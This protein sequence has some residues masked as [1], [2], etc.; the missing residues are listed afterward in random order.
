MRANAA[1]TRV[2]CAGIVDA[3]AYD[4]TE[5]QLLQSK[6]IAILPVSEVENLFFLPSVIEAIATAEGYEGATLEAK[7]APIFEELFTQA[8][9]PKIQLPIVMRYCRRRIDRTLKKID[10]SAAADVAALASDYT[11]KTSALD[12]AALAKAAA[13]SI[14]KAIADKDTPELLKWYDNKGI[15]GIACK[16]K[17]TTKVQFEQ[18]IV[19]ALRNDSALSVSDAVR[20]VLPAIVAL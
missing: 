17:G 3:D 2:T 20:K 5:A 9:D 8:A 10:L 19:R 4:A 1:L 18:W 12:V 16:A 13:D 11:T 6:G 14:Q 7:L 15:L